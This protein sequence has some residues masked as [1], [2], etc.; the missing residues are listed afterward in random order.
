MVINPLLVAN[1]AKRSLRK[2]KTDKKDAQ[3][4]TKF[5]ME[6]QE[7]ISQLSLSQDLQDLRN[8]ARERESLSH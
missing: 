6:K 4:I 1:F 3:T 7:E 8:L 5:F 2:N